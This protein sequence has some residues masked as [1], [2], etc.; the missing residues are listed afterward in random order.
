M[1]FSFLLRDLV[2][3]RKEQEEPCTL[4]LLL[5]HAETTVHTFRDI[6]RGH[7]HV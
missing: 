7:I 3:V 4:P 6:T 5:I 1:K 2:R